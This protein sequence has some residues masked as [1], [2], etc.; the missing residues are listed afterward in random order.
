MA[1]YSPD[2]VDKLLSSLSDEDL[3]SIVRSYT[4]THPTMY[5]AL[6]GGEEESASK[7]IVFDYASEVKRCF[8]HYM[9][10]PRWEHDWHRQPEYLDWKEVGKGLLKVLKR[11]ERTIDAGRSDIA[12]ETAFLI[13]EVEDR[14]YEEVFLREREDWDAEDLC[15]DNCFELIGKALDS[16]SLSKEQKLDICDRLDAYHHSELLEYTEYVIQDLIDAVR[17]SLLTDDEHLAIMMRD[18]HNEDG[19][20]K[21]SMACGIWD[22]LNELGRLDEAQAFFQENNLIDELRARYVDYLQGANRPEEVM[23]AI[24]EGIRFASERHLYGLVRKWRERKLE[25]LE[26]YGDKSAAASLCQDLFADAHSS[27]VMKHYKKAK[28]LVDPAKWESFRD[29]MLAKNKDLQNYAD[30]PLAEIYKEE[31]L[32]DRLYDHLCN[33]RFSLMEALSRYAKEFSAEQQ[34]TLIARLE[35]EFPIGLG[36]NP[37]RRGYKELAGRLNTLAKICPAGKELASKVVA[38]FRTKYPNRPALMEELA[39]VKL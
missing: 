38:G 23:R 10:M 13:L 27:E 35:K 29:K 21:S 12:I 5:E 3:R 24:E 4:L 34:K 16:P 39:K 28:E 30:S 18:F 15:L 31:R 20:R 19:W 1:K 11:A 2:S 22:Y 25:I 32:M 33:A 14:L 17:G 9:K 7:T 26:N 37:T 6:I 8:C 36:Y